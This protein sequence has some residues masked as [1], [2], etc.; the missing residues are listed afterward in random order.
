MANYGSLDADVCWFEDFE[1]PRDFELAREGKFLRA[2]FVF[3]PSPSGKLL[4]LAPKRPPY[5]R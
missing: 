2:G 3:W 1:L 5:G 4:L